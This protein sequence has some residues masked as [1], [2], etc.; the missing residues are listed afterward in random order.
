MY[1]IFGK[2][3]PSTRNFLNILYS[4]IANLSFLSIDSSTYINSFKETRVFTRIIT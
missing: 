2:K 4:K 1:K 3:V